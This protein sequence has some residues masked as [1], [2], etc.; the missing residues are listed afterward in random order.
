[1]TSTLSVNGALLAWDDSL[2]TGH[3][4]IDATH[5][6]FIALTNALV[7]ADD[8]EI[9]VSLQ[10]FERHAIEHFGEEDRLMQES[11]FPSADCHLQEHRKVL[12]SVA[13]V[14]V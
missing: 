2:A 1:M 5:Q 6:E 3:R 9:L 4:R 14:R 7:D 8:S 11:R 12:D 13:Q 10:A